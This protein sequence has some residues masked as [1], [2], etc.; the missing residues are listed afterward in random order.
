M[1]KWNLTHPLWIFWSKKWFMI[2]GA[3]SYLR[4]GFDLLVNVWTVSSTKI[5]CYNAI[6]WEPTL[7]SEICF[8]NTLFIICV[9][10]VAIVIDLMIY[11]KPVQAQS[12]INKCFGKFL[13][14]CNYM[15]NLWES[16]AI[17]INLYYF[18]FRVPTVGGSTLDLHR[19]FLEVTSRGGIEKVCYII[20]FE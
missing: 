2:L 15:W 1:E 5:I 8:V 9:M 3:A 20:S 12:E 19:L 6:L 17:I 13:E 11:M 7:I 14:D 10:V 18:Q 4:Q 16:Y